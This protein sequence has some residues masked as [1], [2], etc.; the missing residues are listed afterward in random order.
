MAADIFLPRNSNDHRVCKL[1]YWGGVRN[2]IT[3]LKDTIHFIHYLYQFIQNSIATGFISWYLVSDFK[4]SKKQTMK[5]IILFTSI[6]L[7]SGLL[8]TNVYNSL[9]DVKSWG[10]DIPNSIAATREYFKTV[11]PGN[12]FRV[13]SPINQVLAL[14]VLI[15]FW[16][17]S[18]SVRL[19]LGIALVLYV[20]VDVLTF[21]YFYPRNDIMFKTAQLTD[22][23]LLK[24]TVLEWGRMNWVRNLILVAG[25]IFS[26]LSLHKIYLL[27]RK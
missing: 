22:T 16:R 9:I 6:T 12:F 2:E 1:G 18:R 4:P 3:T 11:N 13:F 14:V 26:F 21:G 25:V 5:K 20:L 17:A 27:N 19:Y 24:R 7:A 23:D 8:F 10:S 15:S